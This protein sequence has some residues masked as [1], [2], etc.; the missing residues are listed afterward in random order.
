MNYSK[1]INDIITRE[2]GY[3]DRA[4]DRGGSTNFGI[5]QAVARANGFKGDMRDL[6]RA[7][8]YAI[9]E[10]RY[11]LAPQ[12]DKIG[13][14]SPDV[15]AELI[16]TGVNMGPAVASTFFQRWLNAFNARGSRYADLFVDG[17]IGPATI[18]AFSSYMRWRGAEGSVVMVK[19]LNGVQAARYL[20]LAEKDQKQED[21]AYGW[22]RTRT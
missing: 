18:A 4:S 19:A 9:Y 5:T 8:A 6:P 13:L 14:L 17:R 12:F 11:V 15:G 22:I 1:T 20:E 10:D 7:T 21:F 3:S 2:G 16:D